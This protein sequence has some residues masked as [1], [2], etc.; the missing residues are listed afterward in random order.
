MTS[1]YVV[2][3]DDGH[4]GWCIESIAGLTLCGQIYA[5]SEVEREIYATERG[6]QHPHNTL[7]IDCHRLNDSHELREAARRV[8]S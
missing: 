4:D 6:D 3:L 8:A 2:N 7:C 1:G 5:P